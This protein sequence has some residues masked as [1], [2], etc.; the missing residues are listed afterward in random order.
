MEVTEACGADD[1]DPD[2]NSHTHAFGQFCRASRLAANFSDVLWGRRL[3]PEVRPG[4]KKSFAAMSCDTRL[5]VTNQRNVNSPAPP[6]RYRVSTRWTIFSRHPLCSDAVRRL[7]FLHREPMI[8]HPPAA[9]AAA[10][11]VSSSARRERTRGGDA[12]TADASARV[13]DLTCDNLLA[14][15]HI[16][17]D[18]T[19][20]PRSVRVFSVPPPSACRFT[21]DEYC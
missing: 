17:Q 9:V 1:I 4:Q 16:I 2:V 10:Q 8:T 5:C 14:A 6:K 20:P 11:I 3:R 12:S 21:S 19:P 18:D 7:F 13:G 15:P